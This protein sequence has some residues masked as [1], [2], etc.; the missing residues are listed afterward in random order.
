MYASAHAAV[1]SRAVG[2]RGYWGR[3]RPASFAGPRPGGRAGW[4]RLATVQREIA[5]RD[6]KRVA[7]L[8][9]AA[10]LKVV[11][12]ACVEDINWRASRLGLGTRLPARRRKRHHRVVPDAELGLLGMPL[13]AINPRLAG[14]PHAKVETVAVRQQIFLGT[15]RCRLDLKLV[16]LPH[17]V[18]KIDCG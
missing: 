18:P 10:R 8:M 2:L 4:R 14:W 13:V 17:G 11:S 3:R 6:D 16:E 9:K 15:R 7:R 1:A 5:W 12:T